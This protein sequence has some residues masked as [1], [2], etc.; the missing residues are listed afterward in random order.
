MKNNALSLTIF[1]IRFVIF[2]TSISI[3][4]TVGTVAIHELGHSIA[5]QK[6]GCPYNTIMFQ[7]G[8]LPNTEVSCFENANITYLLLAGLITTTIFSILI[9]I[10]ASGIIRYLAAVIFSIGLITATIDLQALSVDS[11]VIIIMSLISYIV[12]AL[13]TIKI[14]MIYFKKENKSLKI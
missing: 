4:V 3:F 5:A 2:I 10:A 1:I 11:S 6:M 9:F 14:V 8:H 12:L 7:P 13:S